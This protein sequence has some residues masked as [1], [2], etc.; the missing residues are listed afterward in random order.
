MAE[1]QM[2]IAGHVA[3]V[4]T[5]FDSTQ[6]Y[7]SAYLT[8]EEPEFFIAPTDADLEF[9]QSFSIQEALEEGIRPRTYTG[10]RL[11]RAAIQRAF[12]E[13][14]FRQDVL[15]L[16]GSTVAVDGRAYLFTAKCGTGKSTHTR[17]W[18]RHFGARAKMV[19]D[20]KPFLHLTP[21]EVVAYGSPWN[22]K[23]GLSN[24]IAA[25]L[26]GICVLCRGPEN[27]IRPLSPGEILP[28]L[29]SQV[30]WPLDRGQYPRMERLLD[31]LAHAVSLWQMECTPE[32][33]AVQVAYG[34]MAQDGQ[35]ENF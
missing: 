28:M 5:R 14:L 26:Q 21:Q 30:T 10:P 11:E 12:A 31:Q 18:C 3:R 13:Y 20:D 4:Q 16:H 6:S 24:P 8:Q 9:E 34:A 1:F 23:H 19:N 29:R 25:P 33:E 2:R 17:L 35:Q 7:F 27:R 22:G 32:A 15:L